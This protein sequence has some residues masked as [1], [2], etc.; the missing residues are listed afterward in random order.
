MTSLHEALGFDPNDPGVLRADAL[1]TNDSMLLDQLIQ[2]R[3][4]K[5]LSQTEVGRRMG[6]SQPTVASFEAQRDPKLSTIRRYAHAVEALVSHTVESDEGQPSIGLAKGWSV[7]SGQV[8]VI[9]MPKPNHI[10]VLGNAIE[11]KRTD[12]AL[13]A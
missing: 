2:M 3:I 4:D 10:A 8:E 6:V 9:R 7:L 5:G 12:F 13:G 1:V 11:S